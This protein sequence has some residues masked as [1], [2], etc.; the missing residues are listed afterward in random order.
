MRDDYAD[1]IN[2][3]VRAE[4]E[5]ET[6]GFRKGAAFGVYMTLC[7]I[8]AGMILMSLNAHAADWSFEEAKKPIR[9]SERDATLS[10][11]QNNSA[12]HVWH[13]FFVR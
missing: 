5:A 10:V 12:R 7:V 13:C 11:C 6:R 2:P 4:Q 9:A 1:M 8:I 3:Y